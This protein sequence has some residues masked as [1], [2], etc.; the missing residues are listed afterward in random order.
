V[1]VTVYTTEM[2]SFEA[3]NDA[4]AEHFAGDP[5]ARVVVGVAA[6]PKGAGVEVDAVVALTG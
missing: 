5:P 2:D 1:R 3:I 6:L 4:Y